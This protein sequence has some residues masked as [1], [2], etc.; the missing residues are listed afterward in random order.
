LDIHAG[1]ELLLDKSV[2]GNEPARTE[3]AG[4]GETGT[5]GLVGL[6]NAELAGGNDGLPEL[7]KG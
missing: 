6:S 5:P 4:G 3:L 1:G 2:V 7:A